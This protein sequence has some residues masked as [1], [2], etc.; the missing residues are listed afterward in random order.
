M[1][2]KKSI[3]DSI[4][5]NKYYFFNLI[6]NLNFPKKL[7]LNYFWSCFLILKSQLHQPLFEFNP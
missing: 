6:E 2:P 7:I 4:G 1:N 3:F 5:I